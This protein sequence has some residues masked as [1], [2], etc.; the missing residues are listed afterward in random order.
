VGLAPDAPI[1][2]ADIRTAAVTDLAWNP[3]GGVLAAASVDSTVRLFGFDTLDTRQPLC[4]KVAWPPEPLPGG[5][6]GSLPSGVQVAGSTPIEARDHTVIVTSLDGLLAVETNT[7]ESFAWV[8]S[9]TQACSDF[10]VLPHAARKVFGRPD[11]R[12][13]L[14][15]V[16]D[17]VLVGE[18]LWSKPR[19]LAVNPDRT[20]MVTTSEDGRIIAYDL[21]TFRPLCT[22]A[23]EEPAVSCWFS[24]SGDQLTVEDNGSIYRF[25]TPG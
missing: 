25:T 8:M 3:D 24:E 7:S 10:G 23:L 6:F 4:E 17:R 9:S 12:L 15:T 13:E 21:R 18:I 2:L 20:V 19:A 22:L 1:V 11:E 5:V 16:P 14:R